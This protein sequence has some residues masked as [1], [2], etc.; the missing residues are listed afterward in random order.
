MP[1]HHSW[2]DHH[3]E[4]SPSS[5]SFN[6]VKAIRS[7]IRCHRTKWLGAMLRLPDAR[8]TKQAVLDFGLNAVT[9]KA[10]ARQHANGHAGPQRP[11]LHLQ[12]LT[13][14]AQD[15]STWTQHL[16]QAFPGQQPPPA[17]PT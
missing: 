2:Q 12:H 9:G 1:R 5:T 11:M 8:L 14:I 3:E 10:E 17:Q 4:A 7:C 16:R 13:K 6:F 15:K